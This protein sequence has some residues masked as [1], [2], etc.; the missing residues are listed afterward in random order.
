MLKS[1]AF[2]LKSAIGFS[3]RQTA[4]SC[5]FSE[6]SLARYCPGGY[7]PVRIGDVF[8]NGRYKVLCKLWYG[9][10]PAVWLAFDSVTERH[11]ALKLL[12]AGS[13]GHQQDTF[14]IDILREI[15]YK[16]VAVL[17]SQ[18]V[19]SLF[20][21]FEHVGPNGKHVCLVFRAMGAQTYIKPQNIL[22][23]T[24][25]I[26]AMFENTL[27]EVFL[28]RRPPLDQENDFYIQK[29]QISSAKEDLSRVTE[30]SPQMLRAPEVILG[31]RWD[32]KICELSEGA[33]IFDGSWSAS[34]PYT[35]KAHLAQ[36]EAILGNMPQSLLSRSSDRDRFFD[37]EDKLLMPRTFPDMPLETICKNPAMSE[38]DKVRFL[39]MIK[40]MIRLEP[41]DRP[42]ARS[43]LE[44]ERLN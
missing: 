14:E 40:S 6:E 22:L 18:H 24:A 2:C 42:D 33:L 37:S 17:G 8:A 41:R 16:G 31:A 9:V 35:S 1:V 21:S 20:D 44:S 28:S 32:H 15:K 11:V 23:E 12:T 29:S 19:F 3:P 30:V 10:Y 26:N 36:M 7:H 25:G 4:L 27:S 5:S 34:A 43:L 38:L 39:D 13:Y